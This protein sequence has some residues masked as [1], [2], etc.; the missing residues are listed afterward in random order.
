MTCHELVLYFM[1]FIQGKPK[2]MNSK[3]LSLHLAFQ[4]HELEEGFFSHYYSTIVQFFNTPSFCSLTLLFLI[5]KR[6]L[7][8]I[9][10]IIYG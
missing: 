3:K 8:I 5:K 7:W 4:I 10:F 1:A 6:L 9:S 2:Q